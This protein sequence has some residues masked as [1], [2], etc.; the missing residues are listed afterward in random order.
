MPPRGRGP[1]LWLRRERRGGDGRRSHRAVWIIRDGRYQR[2]TGCGA[3]DHRG[4]ERALADY[5]AHKH[6][7][8]AGARARDPSRIPVADV[9]ALY[10][11]DVA[12]R[13]RRPQ[14]AAARIRM[15]LAHF[16]RLRLSDVNGAACRDYAARRGHPAAARRELEDLRAAINHYQREG[17]C[18]GVV[19]IWLPPRPPPR[20]RWLTRAEAARLLWCAWRHREVKGGAPTARHTRRHVAKF[21]LIALYTGTRA[22]AILR[23]A[24]LPGPGRGWIDLERGIFHRRPPAEAETAKRQPPVPLPRRLL[25]HLRRWRRCG[26]PNG[27]PQRYA[28]EWHGRPVADIDRAF[29]AACADAGLGPDV[30]PHVLRHTAATWLLQ[31]GVEPWT[32]AGYLGM[33]IETLSR[34][35]G[36]HHPDYL[37]AARDAFDAPAATTSA[38]TSAGRKGNIGA[39]AAEKS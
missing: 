11:R 29:R 10:A 38:T 30:T 23:A 36:H 32:V 25:A 39:R 15:L 2:S 22:G 34:I 3:D 5:I 26:G 1:Y 17:L 7:R 35:Y 27:T 13:R 37:R 12:P 33:S 9:L 16:G 31:R 6:V 4:A 19:R 8:A 21:V 20:T 28:V 24:F 14:E 18:H